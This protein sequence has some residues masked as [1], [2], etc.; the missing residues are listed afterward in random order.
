MHEGRWTSQAGGGSQDSDTRGGVL[1]GAPL[2]TRGCGWWIHLGAPVLC[3]WETWSEVFRAHL[4]RRRDTMARGGH[5]SDGD[6]GWLGCL[7]GLVT[8]SRKWCPSGESL[9]KFSPG[10]HPC[11]WARLGDAS[12]WRVGGGTVS[13]APR[14]D[15]WVPAPSAPRVPWRPQLIGGS[16]AQQ[17]EGDAPRLPR[18]GA[19]GWGSRY[20]SSSCRG[21]LLLL[22]SKPRPLQAHQCQQNSLFP[23]WHPCGSIWF[24]VRLPG[25]AFPADGG[26]QL[27]CVRCVCAEGTK[28]WRE[29]PALHGGLPTHTL[30]QRLDA[31]SRP[32]QP[33]WCQHHG[34]SECG[35]PRVWGGR[36]CWALAAGSTAESTC[37]PWGPVWP[38]HTWRL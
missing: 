13:R 19:C 38:A 12:H 4:R 1:T 23:N 33:P 24:T 30:H 37:G 34:P 8:S 20:S 2:G 6:S 3:S 35:W 15:W 32:P 18:L 10:C 36:R 16:Q 21:H 31:H 27:R 14:P 25:P 5:W 11:P 29:Q 26:R 28:P 17:A 7:T 9:G 22:G